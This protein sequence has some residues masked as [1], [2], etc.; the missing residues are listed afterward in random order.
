MNI[1]FYTSFKPSAHKGG[2]ERTTITLANGFKRYLG[3]D[4]YAAYVVEDGGKKED[5]FLDICRVDEK[6]CIPQIE[7][8]IRDWEIDCFIDQGDLWIAA[9]INRNNLERNCR[10][11]LAYHFEPEWDN[12]FFSKKRLKEEVKTES[13]KKK[14][15]STI[16]LLFFPYFKSRYEK[17]LRDYCSRSYHN[18]DRVVLLS[19]GYFDSYATWAGLDKDKENKFFAIPNALSYP[20]DYDPGRVSEKK[21]RVLIVSRLDETQK[22][23]SLALD[24]WKR[25]KQDPKAKEWS[26]DIVGSGEDEE[27][28]K[29][30]VNN[31]H[32][33]D[34]VFYGRREPK[35]FYEDAS[36]FMMTSKSEG[37]GITITEAMQFGV[38]PIVYDTVAAF[39]EMV[40]DA[41]N[42]RLIKEGATDSYC[43][44]LIELIIDD[45]KRQ[46]MARESMSH[47]KLF[48][49]EKIVYKWK[50]LICGIQI[51]GY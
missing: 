8:L 22:R 24:I 30:I 46:K 45:N 10:I 14:L 37:W 28:Y 50:D 21:K 16:K 51:S 12:V 29:N 39:K 9:D 4:S 32:I 33:P 3:W 13:I 44:A 48:E 31:E 2:T 49:P 6:K 19:S 5:C 34:V 41:Q 25:V 40:I 23:I 11:I 17:R 20:M 47:C 7:R 35:A 42:G 27:L 1:L 43:N 38:V 26:L 36:I 15:I 18:A